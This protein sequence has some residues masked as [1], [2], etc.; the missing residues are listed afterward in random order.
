MTLVIDNMTCM[1]CVK[2]IT[3]ALLKVGIKSDISLEKQTVTISDD[4]DQIQ[5]VSI[6]QQAGY[7]VK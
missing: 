4:V 1:H 6:I 2:T 5:V 3:I 7:I